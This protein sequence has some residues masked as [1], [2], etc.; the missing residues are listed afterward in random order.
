[1]RALISLLAGVEARRRC[2]IFAL[3]AVAAMV[4]GF[5]AVT[6]ETAEK[7]IQSGGYYY[8]LG[9]FSAFLFFA[10]R[11]LRERQEVWRGWLRRP[12]WAG[13]VIVA[14]A[15][16][17]IWCDP[18]KHKILFD[19]YVLQGTA[20][21][22]HATK[23]VGTIVR[24]Y[25]LE[26]SWQPLDMFLDKRPY[27][28]AFLVSL[29][30]DLTGYRLINIFI[31]N[32]ALTPVFLGLVYWLARTLT[33]RGPALLAVALLGTMPLLGQQ[34]SGAGMELHNLTMLA[35]VMAL[36]V[37]YLRVPTTDRLA[38]LVLGTLLL[39]QSRYESV[40]FVGPAALVILAGWLRAGRIMLPWPALVAPLLLVPY[41]WHKRV[42]D[43]TPRLW[44]LNEGQSARFSWDYLRGNLE[45]AWNFFFNFGPNLANSW[46]LS[47]L[48]VLGVMGV[49]ILGWRWL[50]APDRQM[51]RPATLVLLAFGV[52]I[53]GDLGLLK[54]FYYWG[55]LD[56]V[57]ASR[58]ALPAC[59]LAALLAAIAV[60]A[61]DRPRHRLQQAAVA[62]LAI[63][64]LGW[65]FPAIARRTYTS[66]N[67]V[68]QEVEWEHEQLLQRRGPV[69]FISNKSTIPFLLWHVP[70]LINSVGRL[71]GEQI[72]YHLHEGTLREVIVSQALR[73]T[74]ANGDLGVDPRD[75]M[76]ARYRLEPFAWKRFGGRWIRLSRITG[77]DPAEKSSPTPGSTPLEATAPH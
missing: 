27:F 30:H 68:M 36:A 2:A 28:F 49:A 35:G 18:F 64:L 8:V 59:M 62:G 48:G 33:S 38:L 71:R 5:V 63:W 37:L 43:A 46:Y 70:A 1:V 66:A 22:M 77:I 57:I 29:L 52:G 32:A 7:L 31:L 61:F 50:R 26:G 55:R 20:F 12:G 21:Q 25:N 34:S 15:A 45:G 72:K 67:L 41:A 75:V 13:V 17:A 24:A 47:V 53:A 3:A 39:S 73:P 11:V 10:F 51:P 54:F 6:P 9:L 42:V 40:I 74:S 65:G 76:P 69:L 14:A 60:N 44:Q 19:E 16:F 4:L 58:L 23:E 56:D